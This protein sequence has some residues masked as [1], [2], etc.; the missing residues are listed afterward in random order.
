VQVKDTG[1]GIQQAD[2]ERI[3]EPF[4]RGM[5]SARQET[6]GSGLGLSVSRQLLEVHGGKI[7][8]ESQP[9]LGSSFVFKLPLNNPE[10][11]RRSPTGFLNEQWAWVERKR[12]RP[13]GKTDK[14]KRVIICEPED[15]LSSKFNGMEEEVEFVHYQSVPAMIED[16]NTTPAHLAVINAHSLQDLLVKME[17]AA[18][19]IKETPIIGCSFSPSREK[20]IE[21]GVLE[22]IQKPFSAHKLR[23]VLQRVSPNPER[24]LIIDD[25]V[26]VQQL[27]ARIV[28]LHNDAAEILLAQTAAEALAILA[29]KQPDV[30]LLDLALPDMN[31]WHLMMRLKK[32][33]LH[34][35]IP[36]IIISAHDLS[37]APP[38]TRA[39]VITQNGG[40]PIE[41]FTAFTMASL[42]GTTREDE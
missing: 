26:E 39:M 34:A 23:T 37:D 6:N 32:D 22:Y 33:P 18:K 13:V 12:R 2:A 28:S 14:Q 5:S 29:A 24:I 25:N 27:I 16:A 19:G 15:F 31:G 36:I 11:P 9:G 17:Q 1:P 38:N 4:V 8:V 20:A 30:I 41:Q 21:T 10:P 35:Q 42:A 7:W 40:F 3:F